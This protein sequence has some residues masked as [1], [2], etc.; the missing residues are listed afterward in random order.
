M[1]SL[2]VAISGSDRKTCSLWGRALLLAVAQACVGI[3]NVAWAHDGHHEDVSPPKAVDEK[4]LYT[5]TAMPERLILTWAGDP[6]RTQAVTWRTD[7]SVKQA[8][9]QIAVAQPGPHFVAKA[10]KVEAATQAYAGDLGEVHFHTVRFEGLMP[11]TLY[12][13]RVGD[14]VNFS[15]WHHFRTMSRD[16]KP[17][18]FIYF[19]DAQNDLKSHW[20]RV[21]REAFSD[22]PRAAFM[23]HAG[24]LVNRGNRDAEWAEWSDAGGWVNATIPTLATVGNHE[25]DINRQQPLPT[26][27]AALKALPRGLTASWKARFEFP[28]NGP[29]GLPQAL[30]ETIYYVDVQGVRIISLNSME[31]PEFQAKWLEG[32]L[33]ENPNHWTVVTHHHPI[34]S[35]TKSR[36][37]P[38]LRDAWQ[39]IYDRYKVDLVLQGHDHAYLRTELKRYENV[40]TGAAARSP[41]GTMYV[42][43]VSGPKQYDNLRD[44]GARRAANTQLYQIITVDGDQLKYQAKTATGELY[45]AFTLRKRDGQVNELINQIP[46][47]PERLESNTP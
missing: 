45:D 35:A 5:P 17:L 28:S 41:A 37:N 42:V 47:V 11:E 15:A 23:L 9:A 30:S 25:Y 40:P 6:A 3:G 2:P 21:F 38:E 19:G 34:Y 46:D 36:D 22:C 24:D 1:L 33:K 39:P 7:A 43:S 29:T 32:V 27:P 10:Q 31:A 4:A 13:Y 20:S 26:D 12:V 16:R 14:G 44:E 18:S 8:Y